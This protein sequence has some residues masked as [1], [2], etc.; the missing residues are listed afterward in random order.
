MLFD[1]FIFIEIQG[2]K[3]G[4]ISKV[5]ELVNC[6]LEAKPRHAKR[7]T[8]QFFGPHSCSYLASAIY[9]TSLSCSLLI[10]KMWFIDLCQR[11]IERIESNGIMREA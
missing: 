9:L 6:Y 1:T 5:T 11:V 10:R 7:G 8:R 3:G 4:D 2:G